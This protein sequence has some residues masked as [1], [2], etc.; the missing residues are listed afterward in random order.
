MA[1]PNWIGLPLVGWWN[2]QAV[3]EIAD[4]HVVTHERNRDDILDAGF[5][6]ERVTF[7]KALPFARYLKD[8]GGRIGP[9]E[10]SGV[11]SIN[12]SVHAPFY[13]DFERRVL[14]KFG[15]R[16]RQGEF[17]LVHRVTPV[18]RMLPSL[19]AGP[20]KKMGVPFV[21][22]PLNGGVP[23]PKGYE[24]EQRRE[25][26]RKLR[27]LRHLARLLPF[28]RSTC[29][30][31]TAVLVGSAVTW[32]SLHANEYPKA[33]YVS[34]Y[35]VDA[36]LF[37]RRTEAY[38]NR[39]LGVA[40]VG[41][42]ERSKGVEILIRAVAPLARAGRV[43]LE[44]IGDGPD[45]QSLLDFIAKEGLQHSIV[46]DGWVDFE[47]LPTRLTQSAVFAYPRVRELGGGRIMEAMMLGLVPVV[48]NFGLPAEIVTDD[49]GFRIPVC[50]KQQL[51]ERLQSQ[52]EQITVMDT[53]SLRTMGERARARV[54]ENFTLE[55]RQRKLA[56]IYEWVLG[57]QVTRPPF[58]PPVD[59]LTL[60]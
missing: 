43:R 11:G 21:V 59:A 12:A 29:R 52:L 19:I 54:M 57:H 50:G 56:E 26:V 30:D 7:I 20:L 25:G 28:Y 34:E 9:K 16:L 41:R 45:R 39:P 18:S 40:F 1:N 8:R 32:R 47:Q 38:G 35:T 24:V 58:N 4:I 44:I 60:Y 48:V 22:G 53:A 55:A 3:S 2:M 5:P 37:S 15:K 33:V 14:R 36:T 23:W 10:A 31:A 6:P 27:H 13:Y 49:T 51:I 46:C 42:L 17:D